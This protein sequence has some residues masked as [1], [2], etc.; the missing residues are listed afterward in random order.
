MIDNSQRATVRR[1]RND[2][3]LKKKKVIN[4]LRYAYYEPLN[5]TIKINFQSAKLNCLKL[6]CFAIGGPLISI[7][8]YI[9]DFLTDFNFHIN[10]DT[11]VIMTLE[12]DCPS[13]TKSFSFFL[14]SLI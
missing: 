2:R 6:P 5:V 13:F 8:H 10:V 7:G 14:F 12:Y 1:I 9:Y 4:L 3:H 11:D